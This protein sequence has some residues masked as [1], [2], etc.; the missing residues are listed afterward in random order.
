MTIQ[1]LFALL[2][3]Y[4]PLVLLLILAAPWLAWGICVAVPGQREEPF[5]LSLNL[6]MALISLLM[7]AGYLLYATNHGGWGRVFEEADILLMLAP[8]YYVGVSVWVTKQRLPLSQIPVVRAIQGLALIGVG[9]L[10]VGWFLRKIRI[11]VFSYIPFQY[12][13][14]LILGLIGV[15]YLGYQRLTGEDLQRQHTH[16]STPSGARRR[17]PFSRESS[18]DLDDELETL[19]REIEKDR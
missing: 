1:D 17:S 15:A 13:L 14:L 5:V 2:N 3:Q 4:Q 11:I 19:R 8:C 16:A 10:G 12:L 9:Y 18:Y 6:G 7:A